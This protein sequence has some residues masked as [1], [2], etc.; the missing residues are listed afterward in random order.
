MRKDVPVFSFLLGFSSSVAQVLV[1]RALVAALYGNELIF[2]L[3]LV[4]WLA[5][6]AAGSLL[7]GLLRREDVPW[8][9][10]TGR[11]SVL[12]GLLLPLTVLAARSVR[13]ILGIAPG[14]LMDLVPASGLAFA[15]V[16]PLS[17]VY[18]GLFPVLV[19]GDRSSGGH[20]GAA[21]VYAL[22]AA[23]FVAGGVLVTFVLLPFLPAL[24]IAFVLLAVNL[25][26]AAWLAPRPALCAAAG[27]MLMAYLF[28]SGLVQRLDADSQA[29][30]WPGFR[31]LESRDTVYGSLQLIEKDGEL[32]LFENGLHV[33]TTGDAL[34]SEENVHYA[35]LAHPAPRSLLLLGGGL[36][37]GLEEALKHPGLAVDYVELDP[38]A[39]EMVRRHMPGAASAMSDPRVRV[40]AADGRRFIKKAGRKYDVVVLNLSDPLTLLVNRYYTVE[41]FREV[42]RR[43]SP[44]GVLA[45]S[46]SSSEN[47]LN[48]EGWDYL[49]TVRATLGAAFAEVRSIPGDRHV[50]LAAP[51]WGTVSTDPA[52]L[53]AR[54]QERGVSTRFVRENYF[55]YRLEPEKVTATEQSLASRLP[56]NSDTR[57]SAFLS[58]LVFWST[59]FRSGFTGLAQGFRL[60]GAWLAFFPVALALAFASVRRRRPLAAGAAAFVAGLCFMVYQLAVMTAFQSF[61]GYVYA[62]VGLITA[63]FMAGA[64]T[65]ARSSGPVPSNEAAGKLRLTVLRSVIFA[66]ALSLL[67]PALGA[68]GADW[69]VLGALALFSLAAGHLGG[70]QFAL[71]VKFSG[72][73]PGRPGAIYAAD[74]LGAALGALAGGILFIPLWGV[75][76]AGCF[77]GLLQAA[78]LAAFLG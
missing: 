52:V 12:A 31:V 72:E 67:L 13:G 60:K 45:L 30:Q 77:C 29:A 75:E 20:E 2:V 7:F 66:A 6:I 17:F 65:G 32:S 37:G 19:G 24:S 70:A 68:W 69:L 54:L 41:F 22:E 18:G 28:G 78:V 5:G 56:V 64:F 57:P 39:I 8:R 15:L 53:A 48:K 49:R 62:G 43:L 42:R 35:L 61:Y 38:A 34:S 51:G 33:A 14:M 44:A 74:V 47:Y 50:F 10:L 23:G 36:A 46:V 26:A 73:E 40:I 71:A 63:L 59:H 21:R 25:L 27:G 55:R 58:A 76:A 16:F 9:A 1:M 11:L 3:V 4:G